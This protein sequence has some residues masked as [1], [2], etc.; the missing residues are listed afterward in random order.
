MLFSDETKVDISQNYTHINQ[1]QDIILDQ[2]DDLEVTDIF[3]GED[4]DPESIMAKRIKAESKF[5][6]KPP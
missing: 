1:T 3:D 2:R 6:I 4:I 5:H